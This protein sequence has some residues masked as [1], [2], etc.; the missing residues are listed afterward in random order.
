MSETGQT[1]LTRYQFGGFVPKGRIHLSAVELFVVCI[2]VFLAPYANLRFSELFFTYSDFFFCLSFAIL[3]ISGRIQRRPL[4]EATQIW[5]FAFMLMFV[6]LLIG[7]LF[8]IGL[9][10]VRSLSRS[11]FFLI[12]F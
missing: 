12:C 3:L 8:T 5:L 4:S 6:G 11:I 9:T 2:G 1:L 10:E 7:S